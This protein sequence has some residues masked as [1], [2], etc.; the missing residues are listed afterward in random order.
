MHGARVCA[1]GALVCLF[2]SVSTRLGLPRSSQAYIW[3]RKGASCDK[4]SVS[5]LY[6]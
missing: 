5:S 2:V 3:I 4:T 6:V 1:L